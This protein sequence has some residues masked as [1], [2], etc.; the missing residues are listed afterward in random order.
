MISLLL[1][2]CVGGFAALL[3]ALSTKWD[4]DSVSYVFA[5]GLVTILAFAGGSFFPTTGMPEI[6]REIGN[7][8]PNG[9]ALTAYLQWMQGLG[10]VAVWPL[11]L[12]IMIITV[13]LL[14]LSVL[15][16]PKRRSV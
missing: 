11:L 5:G 1:S 12:R 15:V 10:M 14:A 8:T 16:F 3:T 4:T 13:V 9:A 2:I 6:V 7:W